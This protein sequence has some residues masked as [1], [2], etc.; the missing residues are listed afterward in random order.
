MKFGVR[1]QSLKERVAIA[2]NFAPLPIVHSNLFAFCARAVCDAVNLGVFEAVG[3]Q[4]RTCDEIAQATGLH[5]GALDALFNLLVSLGYMAHRDG[6]FSTTKLSRKWLLDDSP[7]SIGDGVRLFA[8]QWGQYEHL[9]RYLR[10]GEG[11]RTH[12]DAVAMDWPLYMRAMFQF[13]R[14]GAKEIAQKTPIA[15][16]A[17]A[18]LDIGGSHGL[19]SV[20]LCKRIAGLRSTILDLPEAVEASAPILAQIDTDRRVEHRVGDILAD[21]IGTEQYDLVFMSNLVHHF[22]SEQ[23]AWITQ[24]AA[25][26]LKKGGIFVIQDFLRPSIDA[27]SDTLSSVQNLFFS[28]TSTAGV[29]SLETQRAWQHDAGLHA[30]DVIRFVRTPLVQVVAVK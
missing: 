17:T 24:K 27:A 28:V 2:F 29:H 18:M 21:D 15:A 5:A 3:R 14:M 1:P 10:T 19:Y 12:Q 25:R 26:A 4:W 7:T 13:A 6:K 22:S 20:E 16:H 23:N 9:P 8:A 11:Y 30:L